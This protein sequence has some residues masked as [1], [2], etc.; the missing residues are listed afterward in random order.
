MANIVKNRNRFSSA[1]DLCT[2]VYLSGWGTGGATYNCFVAP[3]QCVIDEIGIVSDASSTGQVTLNH[4]TLQ[5]TNVTQSEDLF[6]T[7]NSLVGADITA[8]TLKTI[9]PDQNTLIAEDDVLQF[10]VATVGAGTGAYTMATA[11]VIVNVRYRPA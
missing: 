11:S 1:S 6:A 4:N 8:N 3:T 7:V 5:V 2:N 9:T 10:K